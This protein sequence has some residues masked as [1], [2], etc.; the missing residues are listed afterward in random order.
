M[1]EDRIEDVGDSGLREIPR[2]YLAAE[3]AA[4]WVALLRPSVRLAAEAELWDAAD[5]QTAARLGGLPR[6]PDGTQWPTGPEGVR[7]AFVAAVDCGSLPAGALDVPLP[8]EGV[9]AFFASTPLGEGPQGRYRAGETG[10]TPGRVVHVPADT[11]GSVRTAPPGVP[12][13]PSVR[14]IAQR[15]VVAPFPDHPRV[16]DAFAAHTWE[17]PYAHPLYEYDFLDELAEYGHRFEHRVGGY[18]VCAGDV[19][20]EAA[21]HRAGSTARVEPRTAGPR[22]TARALEWTLLAQ[23]RC[24]PAEGV[25][26]CD[27]LEEPAPPGDRRPGTL[28]WVIR[29]EDL[30]R[31]RFDDAVL[32]RQF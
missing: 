26:G 11:P 5:M 24:D 3:D 28:V 20:Y 4:R 25:L 6:L 1:D 29:R 27:P 19:E 2:R 32:L 21:A 13:F 18:P 7:L 16:R 8:A 12:V 31:G 22:E 9:L 10:P 30:A 15:E 23:F 17:G 14:L